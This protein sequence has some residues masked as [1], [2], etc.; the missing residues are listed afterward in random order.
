VTSLS[1]YNVHLVN[2]IQLLLDVTLV[3]QNN[4]IN[5]LTIVSVLGIPPP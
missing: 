1:D 5:V 2:K 3:Q 4:I